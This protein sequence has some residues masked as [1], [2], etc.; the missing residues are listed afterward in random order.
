MQVSSPDKI[1]NVA[2]VGHSDTGKTTLVSALL[3]T[4]G[5]MS[6]LNRVEDGNAVTDFDAQEIERKIS[7]NVAAAFAPWKQHKVNLLDCPG[8]SIFL[9]ETQSGLHAADAALVCVNTASGIEVMTEK[10][11]Q[12]SEEI[13]LPVAFHLTKMDRERADGLATAEAI[14]ARFSRNALPVQLPIG[15]ESGF[16]GIVDL[17][18]SKAY[19]FGRDGN[20]KGTPTDIPADL[21]DTVEEWRSKLVEAVA[22]S[23]EEL[24]EKFFEEGSLDGEDLIRGLRAAIA[25]RDLFP[26]T[27]GAAEHGIGTSALLDTIVDLAP[28]PADREDFPAANIGG[29]PVVVS[30]D[31]SAPAAALV[32]KTLNDPFSGRV[33]LIRV[34]GGT[35]SSDTTYW[36]TRAEDNERLGALHLVQGKQADAVPSLVAGDIGCVSKL[37]ITNTGDTLGDKSS[38]LKLGWFEVPPPAISFAVEPVA[39]GD[40][41]KIGEAIH[42]LQDEDIGLAASRDPQTGEFLVSGSGQLHVEIAIAK[43]KSRYKVDVILHPPKV[44]YRETITA[45]ADG[46]GRHKK[47]T[48]G[49]GQFADCKIVMEPLPRGDAFEFADEIFGGSIPQNYRPAVEKGIQEAAEGGYSTSYPVVDFKVRLVDGQYH[50]VDSSELAFKIAGSLAFKDAMAKARPTLLEPVMQIEVV[51]PEEY[52]GDIMSDLSQRR[53]R[54][55]GMDAGGNGSQ[56]VKATVPLAEMLDYSQALTSMTQGRSSFTMVYSHYEEVP[57]QIQEKIIAQDKREQEERAS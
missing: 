1:R 16:E 44:P 19:S 56:I 25:Q 3:Y 38:P 37:K 4:S 5:A 20:G 57:R 51:T 23:D 10:V 40:E 17:V 32:F 28:S 22:E 21:A 14:A 47:Q 33:S 34:A 43:L 9:T 18:H 53:G 24:M 13:D 7:I 41:E 50:D 36:N 8:Y 6:R 27:M 42:R 15:K 45:T 26:I 46:H 30:A 54:P 2:V 29:E 39:K 11:W 12:M 31:A 35:L 55:Q 49:R 52:M 48:G